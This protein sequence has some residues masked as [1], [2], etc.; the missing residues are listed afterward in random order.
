MQGDLD[1]PP[2][3]IHGKR[4][5]RRRIQSLAFIALVGGL[6]LIERHVWGSVGAILLAASGDPRGG[7]TWS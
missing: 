3:E 2:I 7:K 5:Q 4:W 6:V 1:H